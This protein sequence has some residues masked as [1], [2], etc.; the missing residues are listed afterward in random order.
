M[1]AIIP[2][3][4]PQPITP[5]TPSPN[6]DKDTRYR[7]GKYLSW[8]GNSWMSPKLDKYRDFLLSKGLKPITV[9]GHLSTI[10]VAYGDLTRDRD[11]FYGIARAASK[12]SDRVELK[13]ITDEMIVR[14][15]NAIDPNAAKVKVKIVQDIA[16]SEMRRLDASEA[17]QLLKLPTL[18]NL[19][20]LRDTAMISIL[21]STGIREGELVAL[22]QEDLYSTLKGEPAI[23]VRRG[24]GNKQRL[25]PYGKLIWCVSLV[26][27]W[28]TAASVA[29]GPVF[30]AFWKGCKKVRPTA[31]TTKGVEIIL[32]RYLFMIGDKFD[33][34]RPHELRRTYASLMHQAGVDPIAIQQNLGHSR[35][36]TTLHYIGPLDI[37][38]RR[39][40]AIFADVSGE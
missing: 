12:S 30:R 32:S 2:T 7:M 13:T 24:K 21:L 33:Y 36:E 18:N 29:D 38:K 6:A 27:R 34:A 37:Q 25:I 1:T 39:P 16:D 10:R 26:E 17:N 35:L 4:D 22:E 19:L 8:V 31:L 14:I 5:L 9:S 28:L 20:G 15:Q 40:P 3:S 23:K 11:Y